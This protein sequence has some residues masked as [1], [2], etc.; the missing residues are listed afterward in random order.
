M[1]AGGEQFVHCREVVHAVSIIGSS[2]VYIYTYLCP[3]LGGVDTVTQQD[4]C[5]SQWKPASSL[6]SQGE[7]VL[8][9]GT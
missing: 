7:H 4:D 9:P 8:I 5:S 2:T 6:L 3:L 1:E